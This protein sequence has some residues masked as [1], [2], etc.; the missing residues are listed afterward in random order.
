MNQNQSKADSKDINLSDIISTIREALIATYGVVEIAN[1]KDKKG[2]KEE[3]IVLSE[4]SDHTFCV[5]VYLT[6][7]SDV[8][9]TETLR[10]AQS[11]VRYTLNKKYPKIV[12]N[13]NVYANG[14]SNK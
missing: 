4:K 7:S 10:S 2:K 1:I 5:D 12:S 3:G 8:K 11:S 6:V 9:I 13:I 14:V